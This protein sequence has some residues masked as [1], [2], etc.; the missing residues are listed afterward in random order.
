MTPFVRGA[1]GALF[2][3]YFAYIGLVTPY[4]SL[5]FANRGFN[6]LEIASL[7][8]MMQITRILGP[9]SWGWLADFFGE[10]IGIMRFCAAL[11]AL[12][13]LFIFLL[14]NYF[15]FLVWMFV[16]HTIL[17]AL[18][19]LGESATIQALHRDN[20]FDQ[21]YGRLR[22]WGSIGFIAMGLFAGELFQ[23]RGIELFPWVGATVLFALALNTWFLYEPKLV[24]HQM[25]KGELLE[26]LKQRPV[27]WFLAS[28]FWMIFGHAALYVFYSLYLFDLG[29]NKFQIGLF[30]TLGV[31]AEVIF[32]YYQSQF[33]S[34]FKPKQILQWSFALGVVRFLLIAYVA[35]TP[36]L[37]FAQLLHGATFG[38]HHSATTK[39]SQRWFSGPLQARGQ[40]LIIMIAYG[41]G[42]SLGGL[43]AGWVWEVLGPN[44]VFAMASLACLLA[45]MAIYFVPDDPNTV[46]AKQERR[47]A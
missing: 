1:F 9:F 6:A 32:F 29:Y 8:S 43:C 14:P 15:A 2:F 33:L 28:A 37:V 21:R 20:S 11:A 46:A 25:Q 3:L 30:W 35:L 13:F 34:R 45:L 10:R 39:L 23:Q 18:M 27:Q 26:V 5:F 24:R 12:V 36:V 47:L 38:A 7:M 22:L 16:V 4:A 42:G 31:A 44:Q 17:S 40:A 19:P 41:F